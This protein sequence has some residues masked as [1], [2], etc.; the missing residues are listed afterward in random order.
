MPF[1][2]D[3]PA[4]VLV[5]ANETWTRHARMFVKNGKGPKGSST[6]FAS[7][8]GQLLN[9]WDYITNESFNGEIN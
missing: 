1:I 2:L 3:Q 7:G 9:I 8:P 6:G 4:V 5:F